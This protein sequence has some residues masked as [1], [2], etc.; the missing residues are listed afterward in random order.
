MGVEPGLGFGSAH[1]T[2]IRGWTKIWARTRMQGMRGWAKI[3][4]RTRMKG[5]RGWAKIWVRTRIGVRLR[6]PNE[7]ERMDQDLIR[8]LIGI[9]AVSEAEMP[10]D[11]RLDP[12]L[13]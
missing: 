10:L 2:R 12:A 1:P 4:A 11:V 6:S 8:C 3:W 7:D 9:S 5:I 13:D